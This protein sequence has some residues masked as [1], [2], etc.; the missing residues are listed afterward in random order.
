MNY[1]YCRQKYCQRTLS[2]IQSK[3]EGICGVCYSKRKYVSKVHIKI[4]SILKDKDEGL[5]N[6]DIMCELENIGYSAT[7]YYINRL[8]N[9]TNQ[10]NKNYDGNK[11]VW[12]FNKNFLV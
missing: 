12:S 1:Q 5:T 8:L 3:R 4:I 9:K 2:S 7:D 11:N 6:K 10:V